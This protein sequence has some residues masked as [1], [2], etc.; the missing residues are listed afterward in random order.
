MYAPLLEVTILS[1]FDAKAARQAK[2][3]CS[4]V[5][6]LQR[7]Y[8]GQEI[9]DPSQGYC[10]LQWESLRARDAFLR[11][12]A[13]EAHARHLTVQRGP[14]LVT[15]SEDDRTACDAI[16]S[17][18]IQKFGFLQASTHLGRVKVRE[19]LALM[20]SGRQ[21]RQTKKEIIGELDAAVVDNAD[22]RVIM[23]GWESVEQ[24]HAYVGRAENKSFL[25]DV[26][27]VLEWASSKHAK[28]VSA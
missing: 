7:A 20:R 17:A 14:F 24:H 25:A 23:D 21:E 1:S 12:P 10:A 15:L 19:L 18:P 11:S 22:C 26:I 8:I 28:E 2:A 13:Y 6:G 5:D 16:F 27:S 3:A 9:E 4:G